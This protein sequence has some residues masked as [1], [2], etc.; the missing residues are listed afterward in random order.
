M[1]PRTA[2]LLLTFA[3]LV[4]A[5]IPSVSAVGRETG[6]APP[7]RAAAGAGAGKATASCS[8][9]GVGTTLVSSARDVVLGPLVLIGGRRWARIKPNAFGRQGYKVPVTLPD[10]VQATLSVPRSMRR[11]VGLVF[12]YAAQDRV[13]TRGVRG[14]DTSVRFTACSAEG[15]PSRTGWPGGLV[16]DRARCVSLVVKVAGGPSVRRRLPLGRRC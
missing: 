7:S 10:G 16:V 3:V 11:R 6:T 12:T 9:G 8:R 2:W 4:V 1:T 5:G 13:E 15:T 14:A